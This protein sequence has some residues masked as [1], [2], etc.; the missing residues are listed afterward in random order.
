MRDEEEIGRGIS[1]ELIQDGEGGHEDE[2]RG[3]EWF[4]S[5]IG[6]SCFAGG[7][8]NC[9]LEIK[10]RVNSTMLYYV[11]WRAT[12]RQDASRSQ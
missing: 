9:G 2:S 5:T 10:Q 7:C 12:Y 4:D 3:R 6:L 1:D 11:T 8:Y